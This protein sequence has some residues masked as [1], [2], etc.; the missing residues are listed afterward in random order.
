[1]QVDMVLPNG[2]LI[3]A[4]QRN[5]ADLL[6]AVKGGGNQFGV[7][8][9]FRLETHPQSDQIFGGM[10]VYPPS[11]SSAVLEAIAK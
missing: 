1:M 2:T 9:N 6:A 7:V 8:Y 10:R 3:T 5:N 11:A 4:N